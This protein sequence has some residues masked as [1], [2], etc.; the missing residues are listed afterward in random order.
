MEQTIT[1]TLYIIYIDR[2]YNITLILLDNDKCWNQKTSQIVSLFQSLNITPS[3][4]V[5]G[6]LNNWNEE[7]RRSSRANIYKNAFND[8][9]LVLPNPIL[10]PGCSANECGSEIGD[11][12]SCFPSKQL[13]MD[14][15][16]LVT[17]ILSTMTT[18]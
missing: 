14:T 10:T 1:T 12:H 16:N 3:A 9:A 18:I 17:E 4:I 2:P 11:G 6:Y 15:E 5:L 13:V 8:S 7:L